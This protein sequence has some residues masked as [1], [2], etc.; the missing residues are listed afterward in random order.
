MIVKAYVEVASIACVTTG[1]TGVI[2]SDAGL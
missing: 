2:E 1:H